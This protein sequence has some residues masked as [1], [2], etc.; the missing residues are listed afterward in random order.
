MELAAGAV[1]V[2]EVLKLW[3]VSSLCMLIG[4]EG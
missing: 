3:D 1:K 4:H 2:T